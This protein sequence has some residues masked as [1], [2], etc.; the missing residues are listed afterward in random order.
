MRRPSGDHLHLHRL[1][2]VH[3]PHLADAD[4]RAAA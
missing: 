2:A 3:P 4:D 1:I